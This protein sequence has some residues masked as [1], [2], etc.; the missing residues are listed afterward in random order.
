VL[1]GRRFHWR[2]TGRF[3]AALGLF[4]VSGNFLVPAEVA[5]WI[6]DRNSALFAS[7][8]LTRRLLFHQPAHG[9]NKAFPQSLWSDNLSGAM[10]ANCDSNIRERFIRR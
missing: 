3:A 9:Q 8:S 7:A 6:F 4:I 5:G 1:S 10:P 2:R